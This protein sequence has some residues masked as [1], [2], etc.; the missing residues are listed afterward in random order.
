M[1]AIPANIGAKLVHLQDLTDDQPVVANIGLL[2]PAVSGN[3]PCKLGVAAVVPASLCNLS[4]YKLHGH[5]PM[6]L[7][8]NYI[9]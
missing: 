7:V 4:L 9:E 2:A 8:T 5:A 3:Q 1:E 6:V